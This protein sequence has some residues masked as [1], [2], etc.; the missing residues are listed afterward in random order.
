MASQAWAGPLQQRSGHFGGKTIQGH[1]LQVIA[2]L[3]PFSSA[4][5]GTAR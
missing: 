5:S 3:T 1:G 4:A 2:G